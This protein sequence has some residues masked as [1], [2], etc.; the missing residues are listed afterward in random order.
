MSTDEDG[1][2]NV[3]QHSNDVHM[4]DEPTAEVLEP[5]STHPRSLPLPPPAPPVHPAPGG[6]TQYHVTR[7]AVAAVASVASVVRQ[8]AEGDST[9]DEPYQP[10]CDS[11][12]LGQSNFE[13]EEEGEVDS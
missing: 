9:I 2:D 4:M 10:A 12:V 1:G 6:R 7:T 13:E 3:T 11:S 8:A 5:I